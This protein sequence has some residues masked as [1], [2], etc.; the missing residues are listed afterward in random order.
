MKDST[1]VRNVA[2]FGQ[3]KSGKTS[4]AEALLFTAG[5]TNRLGKVDEGSAVMDFEPEEIQRNLSINSSFN[6]FTWEKKQVFIIDTPGDDN[7]INEARYASRISDSAIFL[8]DT[9]GGVKFQTEKIADY[10]TESNLPT[11]IFLNKMDKERADLENAVA[12][13]KENLPFD[14]VLLYLPI[15]AEADFKGVVDIINEK[16]YLFDETGKIKATDVPDDLADEI[17]VHREELMEQ[18]AETDDDLI[19]KFLEEGEL[20]K[21]DLLTGLRNG[22]QSGALSPVIPGVATGNL[23]TELLLNC[24]SDL[25][26]SPMDR[27]AQ[28][29]TNPNTE[30]IVERE[31]SADAPFSAL[32]F[33]TMA[34]PY[35]GR[36]TI[37]RVFSG[38]LGGDTFYN[39]NKETNEKFGQL[40]VMEGKESKP[41][42]SL[43]PGMIGAVAK[44]KKTTTG[45]TLCTSS[46]PIVYEGMTPIEP[47]MSFAVT[48]AKKEDEDKLFSSLSKM[49]EEDP[50]LKLSRGD[51]TNEI[52]LAGVGQIH[53]LVLGERIKRK[54]GVEMELHPPKVPY[55]ET[56]RG[57]ARIQGKHKKQSGGRGQFADSWIEIEPLP[58]DSGRDFEFENK[59]VGGAI[60][61]QYIPAVEKG[62]I[63]AMGKGVL[64][65][66]P[67]VGV[68]VS[69]VDGSFHQVDSSEMAFKISGSIAFKKG[70]LEAKPVLLEPI[71]DLAI[72][73][74][75]DSVGDVIGD[76]NSRRGKIMGMDSLGKAEIINA[77]IP[78]AEVLEYSPILT[79][80]TG[81]RGSFSVEFSHYEELPALLVDKVIAAAKEG[82]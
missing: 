67:T 26:P 73:I 51:Q 30:D 35:A 62:V 77:Q 59:I 69:L 54:F 22:V 20:E 4:L 76:L 46:D 28:E 79:S 25:L 58:L 34:D 71:M 68:K 18:I 57:K 44:L 82:N 15:G 72:T 55:K 32:V 7:F 38:T 63:E 52:L 40:F 81:G 13:I 66:Y 5:K 8:I 9:P 60:P 45:D 53:L 1:Q 56:L 80:I 75:K 78:M 10:V 39:A 42:D 21:E 33:K 12:D 74:T 27:P 47:M 41:V 65:G 29:G 49:L 23:G 11:I 70:A 17:A 24:I 50:T 36:L 3:S 2:I 14:P 43:S 48:P 31:P 64:A 37:F 6:H 16:A 19:E 61:R